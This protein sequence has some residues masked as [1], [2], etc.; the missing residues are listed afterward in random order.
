MKK[1]LGKFKSNYLI[2]V[3]LTLK[4][5]PRACIWT[6]PL[7]GIP[8]NLYAPYVTLFMAAIGI[9]YAEIGYI[10]SILMI[11]QMVFSVLSGVIVDKMGRRK[12]TL[13]FDVLSWSVPELLWMCSQN[14]M[15]YAV[16]AVF[17]GMWRITENS[18]Y[19]LLIEDAEK[20][21]TIALNSWAQIMGLVAVFIAPLSKFAVDAFGIIPTM[22][23]LYGVSFVSMTTKFI[24]LYVFSTETQNGLRRMKQMKNKPLLKSLWG[25]KD[26][27]IRIIREKRMLIT[28]CILAAYMLVSTLQGNYWAL[29]LTDILG[30]QDG[31]ITLFAT[32]RSLVTLLCSF[33][34]VPK[35]NYKAI[36][37]PMLL[38]LAVY[39]AAQVLLLSGLGIVTLVLSVAMEAIAI[40]VLSPITGSLLFIHAEEEER[41]LVVGMV[42]STITLIVAVFPSVVG[43]LA[44]YSLSIPFYVIIGLLALLTVLA[45]AISKFPVL[46]EK[47]DE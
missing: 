25:C 5:N 1:L 9:T 30:I 47:R 10:T 43:I 34:L 36:K 18:W 28:L 12:S 29:Y 15:W 11:S 2:R 46:E 26:V 27:Y 37:N 40:S 16:A 14:F 22:R 23:V 8:Y 39:V 33:L 41:A 44:Q 6:E 35:I 45:V 3:L 20:E 32:L 42:Y 7:W 17:N 13:I 19:L 21:Q 31:N 4:G 24:V 38:S